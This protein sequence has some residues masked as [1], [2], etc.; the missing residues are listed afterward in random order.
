MSDAEKTLV[1]DSRRSTVPREA[2]TIESGQYAL[3]L[4]THQ[5]VYETGATDRIV[6]T[7]SDPK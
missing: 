3:F 1:D 4:N 6:L 2:L 5:L 7:R